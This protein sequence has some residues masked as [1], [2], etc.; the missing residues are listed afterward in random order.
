MSSPN[1]PTSN[2]EDAF[3]STNTPD[4]TPASPGNTSSDTPNNS[5]GLVPIESPTLSLFH[6]D[7]YMKDVQ[8]FFAK[9]S[10]IPPP[11]PI[12]PLAVLTPSLV[13]LPKRRSTYEAST[14]ATPTMTQATIR[15]LVA[16]SV[17]AALETQELAFLCPNMVPNT[18]K[19]MEV[20]IRGLPQSIEGTVT[21][22]KPQTLEEAIIILTHHKLKWSSNKIK[23]EKVMSSPNHPTSNIKDAFFSN[24]T[25]DY[26]PASPGN[27]TS[28]SP[29]NSSGLVTIASPTLSL[30]HDDPYMKDVQSF[31]A[32]ESPI[33]P[34]APITPP[35]VLTPSPIMPLKRRSTSEASASATPT[36]TQATIRQSVADSVTAALETQ[37]ANMANTENINRNT[38]PI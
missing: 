20:Y 16:D 31:Y 18:E 27:T 21:A 28:D 24:N 25:P 23:E 14:S 13:M 12:T 37:V 11:A 26:T 33:P 3:S 17:T 8:A 29:N 2:I 1:H 38:E 34:P 7:P 10:P 32:K 36:M 9:D 6:D 19:L 15:Q 5:S 4:Y 35:A 22:S 30:F